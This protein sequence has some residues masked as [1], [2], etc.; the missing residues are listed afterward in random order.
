M[1]SLI[2]R[3][4]TFTKTN[5][6][7]TDQ[8]RRRELKVLSALATVLARN[9]EVVAVAKS[10]EGSGDLDVIVSAQLVRDEERRPT[11]KRGRFGERVWTV[12][13]NGNPRRDG[14]KDSLRST[15]NL[16]SILNLSPPQPE[17]EEINS[18]M[19]SINHG[20]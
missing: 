2:K 6:Q 9:G 20:W 11:T 12:F 15:S 5:L 13:A 8:A 10:D 16:P 17:F 1:L 7:S 18:L 19:E 14:Q 4:T 3:R